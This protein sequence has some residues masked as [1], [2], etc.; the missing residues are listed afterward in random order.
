MIKQFGMQMHIHRI[1]D[2]VVEEMDGT[3]SGLAWRIVRF[4]SGDEQ[5]FEVA[6]FPAEFENG[7]VWLTVKGEPRLR[8][9]AEAADPDWREFEPDSDLN[10]I[11]RDIAL[12]Q[13]QAD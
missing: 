4:M 10:D 13:R 11:L 6:V 8:A 2:I 9:S 5:V 7:V 3:D 12:L 1:S